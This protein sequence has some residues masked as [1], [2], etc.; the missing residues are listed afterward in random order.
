MRN[1]G[2][3][4][5]V[6]GCGAH[7]LEYMTGGL[8]VILGP[9][10]YNFAAGM[11]GGVA[12]VHDPH[13]RLAVQTNP[14]SVCLLPISPANEA[15]LKALITDHAEKTGSRRAVHVLENWQTVLSEFVEVMPREIIALRESQ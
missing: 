8:A 14:E 10:G 15:R 11:T 12:F 5:V 2:A 13:K 7:G 9:V 4:A 1:S 3:T 6:E